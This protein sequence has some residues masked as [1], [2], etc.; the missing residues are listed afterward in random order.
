MT[1]KMQ[2]LA[3]HYH[4]PSTYSC[5]MPLSSKSVTL[6]TPGPGPS[7]VRLALIRA[8]CEI[9]D[10]R[11]VRDDLYPLIRAAEI[12][13]RPPERVAISQQVLQGYKGRHREASSVTSMV[14][15][16]LYR[17]VAQAQGELTVYMQVPAAKADPFRELMMTIGYWGQTDS[18]TMCLAVEEAAPNQN[19][20]ALPLRLLQELGPLGAFFTGLLAEFRKPE[21]AWEEVVPN[22]RR[23][24]GEPPLHVEVYV[25]PMRLIKRSAGAKL[26]VRQ[27]FLSLSS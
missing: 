16:L 6:A 20:C 3:A 17:E 15:S 1:G 26:L 9:F 13:I 12:R 19:E 7:T 27:P 22:E 10:R 24:E 2:W 23:D 14:N 4:F 5:R 21:L 18:L 8:G 11:V 25:W